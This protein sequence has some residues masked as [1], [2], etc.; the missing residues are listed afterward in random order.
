LKIVF[1]LVL[2]MGFFVVT[3]SALAANRYWVGD[4][5]DWTDNTNH[6]SA[7][8]GG[9]PGASVPTSSDNCYFNASSFS[10][11]GQVVTL[12]VSSECSDMNWTG[13]VNSPTLDFG[14][15]NLYIYGNATFISAMNA[16][17]TSTYMY[18]YNV[19]PATLTTNGLILNGI[20]VEINNSNTLYLGSNLTITGNTTGALNID[21]GA[22]FDANDFDIT[23]PNF[24]AP[25]GTVSMG[26]GTWKITGDDGRVNGSAWETNASVTFNAES[27]TL[28]FQSNSTTITSF[29]GGGKTYNDV[30]F[31]QD[32]G[33][34]FEI[35]NANIF[36][37]LTI[38]SAD[39]PIQVQFQSDVTQTV[40]GFTATGSSGKVITLLSSSEGSRFT[41][42]RSSGTV[43]CD[44][45][46]LTD[47]RA[48]GGATWYAGSNS[49]NAS[50]NSGWVFTNAPTPTPT[51]T[52]IPT[53]TPT[54]TPT[55]TP[56]SAPSNNSS[57]NS[58]SSS[59]SSSNSSNS[60]CNDASPVG[61]PDLF[62]INTKGTKATLYFAPAGMPYDNYVIRF[63]PSENNLLYSAYFSRGFAPGVIYYTINE[64]SLNTDYY[65]QV[66][67][68]NGC[69]P[70]KWG[71][72]ISAKT[73]RNNNTTAKYY[74]SFGGFVE[75]LV[76]TFAP[77]YTGSTVGSTSPVVQKDTK[78]VQVVPT[79]TPIPV[80][81]T[82]SPSPKKCILWWCW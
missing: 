29:Y 3:P 6:W 54:S 67:A 35:Y 56:T 14:S 24:Y 1:L 69:M 12:D 61:A 10:T 18:F 4:G 46:N 80:V 39:G 81:P 62:Q 7:S 26:S 16:I 37:N 49:T 45:L 38:D 30:T 47:S 63:G 73:T 20:I 15:S 60:S 27:S 42:S 64:L 23:T 72:I 50:N 22:T 32:G 13:A 68:G 51:S 82:S 75:S 8:S 79:S 36:D 57:S 53:S 78:T 77:K 55:P 66:R 9:S 41:L 31:K 2:F 59:S 52:P 65:F 48:A 76:N 21:I 19:A 33:G 70:G 44:Y 40:S 34:H 71:N 28:I 11:S 17:G 5:G 43:S 25:G 74:K 58:S